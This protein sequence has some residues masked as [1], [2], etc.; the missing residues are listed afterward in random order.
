MKPIGRKLVFTFGGHTI[1]IEICL[2][3]RTKYQVPDEKTGLL[4]DISEFNGETIERFLGESAHYP[5]GHNLNDHGPTNSPMTQ[6]EA[7]ADNQADNQAD[8]ACQ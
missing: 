1:A 2:K 7:E 5:Y 4:F 3:G 6:A 8:N